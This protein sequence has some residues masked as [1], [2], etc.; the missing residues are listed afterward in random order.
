MSGEKDR[1]GNLCPEQ[2]DKCQN[3]QLLLPYPQLSCQN[4][5]NNKYRSGA[6][7]TITNMILKFESEKKSEQKFTQ[8]KIFSEHL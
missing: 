6:A 3:A 5:N 1:K 2:T 4:W 7:L 8:V